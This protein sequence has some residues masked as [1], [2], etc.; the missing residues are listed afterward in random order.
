MSNSQTRHSFRTRTKTLRVEKVAF[1]VVIF[2]AGFDGCRDGDRGKDTGKFRC[3]GN[4]V[5]KRKFDYNCNCNYSYLRSTLVLVA[6]PS[7]LAFIIVVINFNDTSNDSR[8][9]DSCRY[10]SSTVLVLQILALITVTSTVTAITTV[11]LRSYADIFFSKCDCN[12]SS[13]T[14]SRHI[15]K[16]NKHDAHADNDD[17]IDSCI[18]I[19]I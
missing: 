16:A 2:F 8:S 7:T 14:H 5:D 10:T 3:R 4:S 15:P 19:Q 11:R 12:Y 18:C 6:F 13:T 1:V 17:N 9:D